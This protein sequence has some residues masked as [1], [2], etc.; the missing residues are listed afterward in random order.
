[1]QRGRQ[2]RR[3]RGRGTQDGHGQRDAEVAD[4][5][6]AGDQPDGVGLARGAPGEAGGEPA[7]RV[8]DEEHDDGCDQRR[9]G[10]AG[11]EVG[12]GH[13]G[14]DQGGQRDPVDEVVE[15]GGGALA[16]TLEAPGHGADRDHREDGQDPAQ[17]VSHAPRPRGA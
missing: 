6:P 3:E 9:A 7:E 10:D 17:Q 11:G 15:H 1:V 14:E 2:R 13:R 16:E 8:G 12:A 5:A 4:V